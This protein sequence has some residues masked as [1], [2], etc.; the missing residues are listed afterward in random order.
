MVYRKIWV[1][2]NTKYKAQIVQQTKKIT[3]EIAAQPNNIQTRYEIS[4]NKAYPLL[5]L[6]PIYL[7]LLPQ[8]S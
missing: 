8:S 3:I 2:Y 1:S 7:G 5:A 6:R 4:T